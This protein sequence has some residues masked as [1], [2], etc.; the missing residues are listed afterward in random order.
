MPTRRAQRE[1]TFE[2]EGAHRLLRTVTYPDGRSYAHRCTLEAFT[3]V[4][5]A[6][7]EADA[8][9]PGLALDDVAR[10][11]GLPFTQANVALEFLKERGLTVTR[12]R[13][14]YPACDANFEHAMVE[15]QPR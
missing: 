1:V 12:R 7:A 13:R 4:A 2:A 5:H 14:N 3:A 11:E 6:L 8:G 9:G 10:A 15:F